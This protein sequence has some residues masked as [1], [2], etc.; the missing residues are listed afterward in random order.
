M[1]EKNKKKEANM[2]TSERAMNVECC[3]AVICSA[4]EWRDLT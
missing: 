1:E 3:R 4:V 2:V